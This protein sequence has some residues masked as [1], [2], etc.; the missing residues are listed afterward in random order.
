[1][2]TPA[3]VLIVDDD[4]SVRVLLKE[5]LEQNGFRIS[6]ASDGCA[7]KEQLRRAPIDLIV[8]DLML[9]GEDGFA[10]CRWIRATRNTPVIMLTARNRSDDRV[11]G[12]E[13][14]ADDYVAKP[15][16]PRELVARI[17]GVLRRSSTADQRAKTVRA[18]GFAGWELSLPQRQLL[19]P[20]RVLVPLAGS[21][22]QLLVIFLE[23]PQR[24]L[25]RDQL[26]ELCHGREAGPYDR[27]ID[28]RVS[29]LRQRLGD[30]GREPH[31]IKTVRSAGYVLATDVARYP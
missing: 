21:E 4:V 10:L 18:F 11:Q 12:L 5:Y 20:E 15:F 29:Q 31:L 14:G 16:E 6:T 13:L 24:V 25:S 8:L 26:I 17:R 27:S 2:S 23:N 7:L 22:F 28:V 30:S 3:H 1:M 9:P 19:S